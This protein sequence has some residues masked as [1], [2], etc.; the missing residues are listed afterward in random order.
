MDF[1]HQLLDFLSYTKRRNKKLSKMVQKK[2]K[3]VSMTDDEFSIELIE[4]CT[5]YE[6]GR[7]KVY[8][9]GIVLLTTVTTSIWKYLPDIMS[10]M[11]MFRGDEELEQAIRLGAGL[12]A[13]FVIII[14][15]I[16]ASVFFTQLFN[17][18]KIIEKKNFIKYMKEVRR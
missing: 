5:L 16:I 6:Y 15:I 4:T 11:T 14:L 13:M 8:V 17:Y 9:S 7:L 10:K 12:A 2:E 18:R 3:Y 1:K